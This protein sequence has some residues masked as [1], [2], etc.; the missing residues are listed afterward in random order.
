M[1]RDRASVVAAAVLRIVARYVPEI[2]ADSI[3]PL[4]TELAAYLRDEFA[5]V[6][7]HTFNEI[8]LSDE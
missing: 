2:F 7:R 8:R 3:V 6:A 4:H 1:T 5:D